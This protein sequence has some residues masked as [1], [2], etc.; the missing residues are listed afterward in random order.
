MKSHYSIICIICCLIIILLLAYYI[1]WPHNVTHNQNTN[2]DAETYTIYLFYSDTCPYCKEFDPVWQKIA[3]DLSQNYKI[4]FKKIDGSDKKNENLLFYYNVKHYPTIIIS[5]KNK[6]VEF[7]G[8]RIY[9][10]LLK[11]IDTNTK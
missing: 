3:K 10:E 11:F 1:L 6:V 4:A 2:K 9:A 7:S 5:G 8:N